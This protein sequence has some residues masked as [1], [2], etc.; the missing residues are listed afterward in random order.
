MP[1]AISQLQVRNFKC[2]DSKSFYK[3]EFHKDQNPTILSGPNGFGKTTFFDAIELIFTKKITRLQTS[4]EDGR[5]NLGKNILLNE[6]DKDGDLILTLSDENDNYITVVA[7]I[8]HQIQKLFIEE[9]IKYS[10]VYRRFDSDEDIDIFL[11]SQ[12]QWKPSLQ[13]F[14]KL[15]YSMDHFNVYYY[16]SQAE[17]VHFLKNSITNRKD[18]MNVLLNTAT[19]DGYI[20]YITNQLIGKSKSKKGV[21]IN[22]AITLSNEIIETKADLLKSKI[23]GTNLNLQKVEYSQLLEYPI[24]VNPVGWDVETIDFDSESLLNIN[25]A[26]LELQ[27][28]YS[29]VIN[30]QDYDI[31]LHNKKI[32]A[33]INNSDIIN[34]FID[35]NQYITDSFLDKEK[36]RN[37]ISEW[38]KLI[39]IYNYSSFFRSKLEITSYKKGELLKLKELDENLI[40]SN[41]DEISDIIASINDANKTLSNR[42]N[43]LNDLDKARVKLHQLKNDFDKESSNCPFCNHKFEN[44]EELEQSFLAL[45]NSLSAEKNE[46][47]QEI[48]LLTQALNAMLQKDLD[49]ILAIVQSYDDLKIR[50]LNALMSKTKQFIENEKRVQDVET[51]FSYLRK[52]DSWVELRNEEKSIEIQR[53]LQGSLKNYSNAEFSNDTEKYDFKSISNKFQ[54]LLSISQPRLVDKE[55]VEEKIQYL[56]YK[57]SISKSTELNALRNEIKNELLK[58]HKLRKIRDHLDDL[59]KL[60]QNSIDDYKNQI[61]KKLRVPLL[62]YTGKILQD[63]QNGLG[64]FVSKDE[65]RFVSNGD[66]KHDILNTFSSGQL[67]GFVL[68]FLFSMNKQYIMKSRDDIGFILVD[69]PVQ[70]MD[71]INISSLIEVLRN[72]FSNK[73]IIIS[74]HE[75]DKEN[76]ILYKFLKYNLKG[77]SFNVKEK[78]YL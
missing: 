68:A 25:S 37:L 67:S 49:A 50:E 52:S 3:F 1:Y 42:Q 27:A 44:V 59:Q 38:N 7:V 65:M 35:F 16:V 77:Q 39:D 12:L 23:Q 26:I 75:T 8:D 40:S 13:Q 64:V 22:D 55:Q 6:S 19:I 43:T 9:S 62:I 10:V 46:K 47:S 21:V 78:L 69:D 24:D 11:G 71:D 48:Q 14:E 33:L 15:R 29:L 32:N 20:E 58:V 70:T 17:S 51:L 72:D 18:S 63:Y 45:T 5:I 61:L 60:Y 36:I 53:I 28:L 41:I 66:A 57:S 54:K 56:Q 31:Y 34:D 4:I 73:Q 74:T 2:F 76:Y 30:T